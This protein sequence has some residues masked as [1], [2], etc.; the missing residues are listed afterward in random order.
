MG[1]TRKEPFVS[2]VKQPVR[3]LKTL[4]CAGKAKPRLAFHYVQGEWSYYE[5][6][7]PA[8][9]RRALHVA[10]ERIESE[11]PGAL[12]KA[13]AIDDA[14]WSAGKTRTR[15]YIATRADQIYPNSPHLT[16]GHVESVCGYY[17]LTNTSWA[18]ICAIFEVICAGAGIAYAPVDALAARRLPKATAPARKR[19]VAPRTK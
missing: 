1:I 6:M 17:V 8:T 15:R 10:L 13:V 19:T 7:Q 3:E 18:G 4:F 14:N 16:A 9:V 11:L 5:V 12:A 2:N